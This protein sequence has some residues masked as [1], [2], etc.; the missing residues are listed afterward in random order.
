MNNFNLICFAKISIINI[1]F[2]VKML[3]TQFELI[4]LL[5]IVAFINSI[6]NVNEL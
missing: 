3:F 2:H 5:C 1:K 4:R 6:E